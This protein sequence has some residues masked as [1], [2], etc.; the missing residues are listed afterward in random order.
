MK[1]KI[2]DKFFRIEE[3][4]YSLLIFVAIQNIILNLY[5]I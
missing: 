1:K 4:L 3:V 5:N 2:C